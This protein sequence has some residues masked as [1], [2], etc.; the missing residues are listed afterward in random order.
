MKIDL[1]CFIVFLILLTTSSIGAQVGIGTVSPNSSSILDVYSDTKGFLM[2]RLST[3]QRDAMIAPATGLMIY[4]HTKNDGQLNIGTPSDPRWVGIRGQEDGMIDTVTEGG[5]TRTASI[6]NLPL[7]GMTLSPP[8]G[9]YIVIFNAQQSNVASFN[10]DQGVSDT[11]NLYNQLTEYP[12][13][14]PHVLTFGS[15]ETLF[16]GV[17]NVSGAP[18]IAGTLT[19][20]GGGDPNSVFIIRGPG[21]FTTAAGTSVVLTNSAQAKNIFWVSNAAM[22]TAA[23]TTMKGT[24]LGGG[25][26]AGAVSLGADSHLEGRL[27]TKLG[28][29]TFGVNVSLII[30][31]GSSAL[32]LGVMSSFAM[33][34]SDGAV[35]DLSSGTTTGDVGTAL[36]T[37]TMAGAHAGIIYA[38]GTTGGTFNTTTYSIYQDGTQVNNS[39]RTIKAENA[40]VSLQAKVDVPSG[41]SIEIRWKVNEGSSKINNRTLSL[42][43]LQ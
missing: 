1:K 30:P 19:M 35:S 12:G 25:A 5:D 23:N 29:I 36:G 32:N 26:G 4:N 43:S 27:F 34:S 21:A 42:I 18:S 14:V 40:I 16:P 2:P 38:A 11:A 24:M 37:I 39:S 33:W 7:S 10:S 15:G 6:T 8:E 41:G 22:S 20:D 17:Y 28:A 9:S 3:A 13:G 31:S